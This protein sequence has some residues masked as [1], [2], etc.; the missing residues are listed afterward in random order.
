[1][2]L[3]RLACKTAMT[4]LLLAV[5]LYPVIAIGLSLYMQDL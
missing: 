1:M 4:A 3:V 5:V 2:R